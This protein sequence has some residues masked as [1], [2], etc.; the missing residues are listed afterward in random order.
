MSVVPYDRR[1]RGAGEELGAPRQWIELMAPAAEL[2]KSVAHTDFVPKALRGNPAAIAAAILYGDE[3]GLGPMQS[4]AKVKVIDGTPTLAAEAQRALILAAGHE[5]W[6]EEATTTRATVGGRRRDSER[7]DRITWTIEDARRAELA[8]RTAWK[9]YPRAMLIARAS[10]ELARTLFPDA[11][12]GF[13]ATEELEEPAELSSAEPAELPTTRARRRSRPAA[14]T[15]SGPTEPPPREDDG[16]E[17]PPLPGDEPPAGPSSP[18][19]PP[20]PPLPGDG[21]DPAPAEPEPPPE[22]ELIT[23]PQRKKMMA[24]F[25]EAGFTTREARLAF[26]AFHIRRK[27]SSSNELTVTEASRII[28]LLESAIEREPESHEGEI[29]QD[30]LAIAEGADDE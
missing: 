5:L 13:A 21:D 27:V 20:E 29:L 4:L 18:Q 14:A 17:P 7:T 6:L 23:E 15:V 22:P 1:A 26:T 16:P 10:A 11:I 9:R 2:A 25:K 3:V 24:D 19:T 12:G 8:G 28:D 30:A